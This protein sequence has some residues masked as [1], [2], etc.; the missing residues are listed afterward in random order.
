MVTN[1]TL[2]T[3]IRNARNVSKYLFGLGVISDLTPI[4]QQKKID[5]S[6]KYAIFFFIQKTNNFSNHFTLVLIKMKKFYIII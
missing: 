3:G 2:V 6:T 1:S 4:L 5:S